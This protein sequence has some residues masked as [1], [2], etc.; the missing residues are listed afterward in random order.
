MKAHITAAN[1]R[2]TA[3]LKCSS[4]LSVA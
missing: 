4:Y 3:L 2:G 1:T